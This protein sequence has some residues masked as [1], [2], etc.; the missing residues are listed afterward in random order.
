[1]IRGWPIQKGHSGT[2]RWIDKG[3][4]VI[5]KPADQRNRLSY[6][7]F[8]LKV[9]SQPIFTTKHVKERARQSILPVV[10]AIGQSIY[11][12]KLQSV[13][14]LDVIRISYEGER[15]AAKLIGDPNEV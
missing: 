3:V 1:M 7:P 14:S 11:T 12:S 13:L 8:V 2:D 9:E 10:R 4:H 6:F 5:S 15:S